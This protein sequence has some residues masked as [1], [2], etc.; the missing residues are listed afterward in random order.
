MRFNFLRAFATFAGLTGAALAMTTSPAHA[1]WVTYISHPLGISF[2]GPVG[3]KVA[4][5]TY[6]SE[7]GGTRDAIIYRAV[8]DNIEY[9]ATVVDFSFVNDPANVLRES[10]TDSANLLGEAEY[11][12]QQGNKVL[13]D[14]FAEVDLLFGRKLAVDRPAKHERST[15]VFY[16]AGGLLVSLEATVLPANGDFNTPNMGLFVDSIAFKPQR[17]PPNATE[18]PLPAK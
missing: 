16:F 13:M 5:G 3:M 11:M 4:K 14:A 2:K 12:F 1:E 7:L 18:L 9:K 17:V 15:A 10:A 6:R 8:E